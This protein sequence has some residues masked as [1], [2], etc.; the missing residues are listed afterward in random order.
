MSFFD[1][2]K[3]KAEELDLPHKAE[4]LADAAAKAAHQA[5][6][7]AGE[8]A[9][10][11][12]DKVGEVLEK[13]TKAI[14][15]KTEGKYHD[16]VVKAKESVVKGV[17]KLAEQRPGPAGAAGAAAGAAG[18]QA[19]P[20]AGSDTPL[21]ED[22]GMPNPAAD[23]IVPDPDQ[24]GARPGP[25]PVPGVSEDFPYAGAGEPTAEDG[26]ATKAEFPYADPG[27]HPESDTPP[28]P[29]P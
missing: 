10:Q 15:E 13:A 3:H 4:E 11:N 23:G 8:L 1:K 12:R 21:V 2:L 17:D 28:G 19:S 9:H 27:S 22:P 7:K 25:S 24:P 14:D 5:R 16:K 26:P 6:E 20:G 29:M 18:A